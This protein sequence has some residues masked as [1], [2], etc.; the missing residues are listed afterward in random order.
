MAVPAGPVTVTDA[1]TISV[2]LSAHATEQL[3]KQ[4]PQVYNTQINDALLTALAETVGAWVNSN[5]VLIH[6]E[7]HGREPL[8]EQVD[9][10]RTVGWFTSLYP[11]LLTLNA[12]AS[13]TTHLKAVKEE[14]RAIPQG[15]IGYGLLRYMRLDPAIEAALKQLPTPEISFNYLGQIEQ[16]LAVS[17]DWSL[18]AESTGALHS[19]EG[20]RAHLLDV[21]AQ[22]IGGG[23][24][25]SWIYSR[26]HHAAA[27]IEYLAQDYLHRLQTLIDQC[28]STDAG[29][30]TPSDFP[31]VDLT[32]S[33][34]D[35]VLQQLNL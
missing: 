14:L 26:S 12:N 22:V 21:N 28:L 10:S 25:I 27:T 29:G 11:V 9:L 32:Q 24:Q 17:A 7:G 19:P 15:G 16:G 33:D 35:E 18:A 1:A 6:L 4:V 2:S 30:Y 31:L 8:F 34:L 3:L 13:P 5:T 23:L 20:H